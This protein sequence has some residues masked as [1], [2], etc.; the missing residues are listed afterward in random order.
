MVELLVSR[1]TAVP[2][3]ERIG[4][5][6][7]QRPEAQFPSTEYADCGAGFA[8]QLSE[9]SVSAVG[10]FFYEFA[11]E[12]FKDSFACSS[13]GRHLARDVFNRTQTRAA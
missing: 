7:P 13:C 9:G 1:W 2:S 11:W 5:E 10:T 4:I 8:A 3:I 12:D 6:A